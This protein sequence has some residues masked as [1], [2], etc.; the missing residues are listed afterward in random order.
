MARVYLQTNG[1]TDP[2]V[3]KGIIFPRRT[4]PE[5]REHRGPAELHV[6]R[7][8]SGRRPRQNANPPIEV[9]TIGFDVGN[10]NCP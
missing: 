8:P 1:R 7:R 9:Y 10:E 2:K 5:L 3:K 4:A 6:R